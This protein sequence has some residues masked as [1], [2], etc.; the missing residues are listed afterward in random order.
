MSVTV[1]TTIADLIAALRVATHAAA[2]R[3]SADR[4]GRDARRQD[5]P[6]RRGADEDTRHDR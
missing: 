3:Q 5:D 2:D 6:D 4:A 1:R